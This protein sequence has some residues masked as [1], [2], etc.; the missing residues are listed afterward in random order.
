MKKLLQHNDGEFANALCQLVSCLLFC[1]IMGI[2]SASANTPLTGYL[3]DTP[4]LKEVYYLNADDVRMFR[5]TSCMLLQFYHSSNGEIGLKAWEFKG[6]HNKPRKVSKEGKDAKEERVFAMRSA[7]ANIAVKEDQNFS[8]QIIR[9]ADFK[10]IWKKLKEKGEN[11]KPRYS[12]IAFR[13]KT[14][15]SPYSWE[16]ELDVNATI[17]V[18]DGSNLTDGEVTVLDDY[19]NPYPPGTRKKG[20]L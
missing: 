8:V 1:L 3:P 2:G 20:E 6:R 13:P 4:V 11:G 9:L 16:I 12:Y 15:V 18:P 19:Y 14:A 17:A 10:K 7:G 5:K